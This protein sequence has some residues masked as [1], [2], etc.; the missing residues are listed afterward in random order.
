MY[1]IDNA[2]SVAVKPAYAA[3][4]ATP[5]Q[6]FD[7]GTVWDHDFANHLQEEL[8]AVAVLKGA[9]LNKASDTQCATALSAIKGIDAALATTGSV[10]STWQRLVASSQTSTSSGANSAVV[11]SITGV[12]SGLNSAVVASNVCTASNASSL[13]LSSDTCTATNTQSTVVASRR[14]KASGGRATIMSSNGNAADDVEVSGTNSV[15]IASTGSTAGLGPT[16]VSSDYAAAIA[17]G[18]DT[19]VEG[20]NCVSI[21][22][23]NCTVGNATGG[24]FN[25]VI[26]SKVCNV[27]TASKQ[28]SAVIASA[29]CDVNEG[30][31]AVIG[32]KSNVSSSHICAVALGSDGGGGFGSQGAYQVYG[33]DNAARKWRIQSTTGDF[34]SATGTYATGGADYAEYFNNLEDEAIEPGTL[35]KRKGLGVVIA[36]SGDRVD[37]VASTSPAVVGNSLEDGSRI[38]DPKF[39]LCAMLG[40]VPVKVDGSIDA[41]LIEAVEGYGDELFIESGDDGRGKRSL[42]PTRIVAMEMIADGLCMCLIR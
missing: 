20:D 7:N 5:N 38:D 39:A 3:A 8:A 37:F 42:E 18:E 21:A 10:T 12:S 19:D 36:E 29:N 27:S 1:R 26:A 35:L 16:V 30:T 31:S 15:A 6:Y 2:S 41:E 33:G 17:S 28:A 23:E 22:S 32:C 4:G 25:A 24:T 14:S 9:A 34:F 13:A 40:Q 11:A